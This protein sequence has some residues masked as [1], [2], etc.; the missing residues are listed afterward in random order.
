LGAKNRYRDNIEGVK[1][2]M[3]KRPVK[4][5]GSV[6][7]DAPGTYPWWE[8]IQ[9]VPRIMPVESKSKL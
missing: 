2:Y 3:E 9:T 1:S 4:F 6:I 7:K 8:Q 5:V